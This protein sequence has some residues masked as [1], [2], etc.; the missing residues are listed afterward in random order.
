MATASSISADPVLPE[1]PPSRLPQALSAFRHR[2]YRLFFFGQLISV[3]GT[4][5]QSLAQAWLVLTL[6]SSAFLLGLV[7]VFQFTPI[8][9]LG[10]VGGVIADR[11]PKRNLLVATQTCAGIQAS[12]LATL[13]WTDRVE[14]WHVYVLAFGLGTVNAFDMPTRQSFVFEMVGKDDLVNAVALNSALFNA[15][16]LV[17]PAVAGVILATVGIAICFAINAVSYIAVIGGLLMMRVTR[18]AVARKRGGLGQL[19][20]GLGYVRQTP[21]VFLPIILVGFVA[22]FGMNFNSVWIPLLAKKEFDV[23]AGGFGV[24]MAALGI[25]SLCGAVLLAARAKRPRRSVLFGVAIAVGAIELMLALAGAIPLPLGAALVILPVL[26]FST[27]TMMAMAN[28]TVQTNAPDELRG[29]VMSVYMTVFGGTAPFG[30]L[31]AGT[32]AKFLGTP[33]SVAIGGFVT[34]FAAA[35]IAIT[36]GSIPWPVNRRPVVASPVPRTDPPPGDPPPARR[37]AAPASGHD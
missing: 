13:V 14:L 6:T 11:V 24:L 37:E 27:T 5:M 30:A 19:R 32:T 25:G 22:T 1:P 12:I 35:T 10:L 36:S 9:L 31:L 29:R 26:G 8:L 18:R 15:A 28:S 33:A 2:N 16:R 34:L 4:W 17:G 20:E 3:T 7:A 23:G 21:A